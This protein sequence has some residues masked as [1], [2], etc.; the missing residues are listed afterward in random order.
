MRRVRHPFPTDDDH[1]RESCYC[2]DLLGAIW[3]LTQIIPELTGTASTFTWPIRMA[4]GAISFEFDIKAYGDEIGTSPA[5]QRDILCEAVHNGDIAGFTEDVFW[6]YS[7]EF[8]LAVADGINENGSFSLRGPLAPLLAPVET[9][10]ADH[11]AQI[12]WGERRLD[13]FLPFDVPE[14]RILLEPDFRGSHIPVEHLFFRHPSAATWALKALDANGVNNFAT[15]LEMTPDGLLAMDGFGRKSLECTE[16][17]L[18]ILG[19][20]LATPG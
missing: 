16:Q 14:L 4:I 8:F 10:T 1:G 5:G 12:W 19:L 11:P 13:E 9:L 7:P 17:H 3:A 2:W 18:A 20:A 15:L 6:R